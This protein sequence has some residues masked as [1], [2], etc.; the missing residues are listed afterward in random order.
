[1]Q[2]LFTTDQWCHVLLPNGRPLRIDID[3][4][5]RFDGTGFVVQLRGTRDG[6]V[7][8]ELPFITPEHP[9]VWVFVT[10]FATAVRLAK[11]LRLPDTA[12]DEIWPVLEKF[13]PHLD[14]WLQDVGSRICPPGSASAEDTLPVISDDFPIQVRRD[15]SG[16]FRKKDGSCIIEYTCFREP[17]LYR[18][19]LSLTD[20]DRKRAFDFQKKNIYEIIA[21]FNS[22]N[23]AHQVAQW[24]GREDSTAIKDV[25]AVLKLGFGLKTGLVQHPASRSEPTPIPVAS[26]E[27]TQP[28][29]VFNGGSYFAL[30]G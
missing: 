30:R 23:L 28:I 18:C 15:V 26:P 24:F 6:G 22:D 17:K 2:P 13:G 7:P 27:E 12:V 1:M 5:V 10:S 8:E 21:H 9:L 19:M 3:V 20:G 14:H 4:T 29:M 11:A 16:I 25:S